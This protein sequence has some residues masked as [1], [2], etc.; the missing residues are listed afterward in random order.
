M[1]DGRSVHIR[2]VRPADETEIVQAFDRL[3]PDAR[4]MRFMRAVR[5]PKLDRL[6][7]AL[8]S[9]PEEGIGAGLGTVLMTALIDAAKDRGVEDMEGFV[10]AVN[11]PMLRLARRLGFSITAD[12]D[13]ASVR[14]CRLKLGRA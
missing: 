11:Q 9:F 14:V 13:D 4:R 5:E 6:R 10:L 12:P 2:A 1:R 3:S 7:K 8:A